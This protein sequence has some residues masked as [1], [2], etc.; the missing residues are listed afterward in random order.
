MYGLTVLVKERLLGLKEVKALAIN[1]IR[2]GKVNHITRE[3]GKNKYAEGFLS[4]DQVIAMIQSCRGD[5]YE[6]KPHHAIR[7]VLVHIMKPLGKYDGY[8]IKF[9]FLEPDVI[10]LSIHSVH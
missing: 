2:E 7:S 8:Y 9:Y 3:F 6:A 5:R 1:K 10:F 4:D